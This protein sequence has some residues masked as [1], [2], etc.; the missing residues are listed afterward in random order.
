MNDHIPE[1]L[2][3]AV[4]QVI[5]YVFNLQSVNANQNQIDRPN[6]EVPKEY[7]FDPSGKQLN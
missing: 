2:Y 3:Y 6:P 4:A 7:H 1:S 5:A